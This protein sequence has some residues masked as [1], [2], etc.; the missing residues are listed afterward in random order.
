MLNVLLTCLAPTVGR[1]HC[2]TLILLAQKNCIESRIASRGNWPSSGRQAS[3]N[4][5]TARDNLWATLHRVSIAPAH[6]IVR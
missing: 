4:V 3:E 6:N 2:T 1:R 5:A